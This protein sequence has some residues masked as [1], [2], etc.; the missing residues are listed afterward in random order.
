MFCSSCGMAVTPGLT[1]CN[2]CGAR[3]SEPKSDRITE[4][5][6]VKPEALVGAMGTVLIFGL[7]AII[8]LMMAMK[9]VFGP[10][11]MHLVISG[12]LLGFLLLLAVEGAY[13]WKFLAL[14]KGAKE[15]GDS[16]RLKK[17]TARELDEAKASMFPETAMSVTEHTTRTLEPVDIKQKAE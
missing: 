6:E 11:N 9:M 12:T 8:F 17:Q 1:Y 5:S 2:H 14:K 4:S 3:L 15:R 7:V 13:I 10:E 16:E